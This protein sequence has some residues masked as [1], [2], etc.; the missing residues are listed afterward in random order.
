MFYATTDHAP[1]HSLSCLGL[2]G[3]VEASLKSLLGLLKNKMHVAWQY[4]ENIDAD[5]IFYNP[6]SPLAQAL[7]RREEKN[8][9]GHVFV[10][11]SDEDPGQNGL[12]LPLRAE[13]LLQCLESAAGKVRH[14]TAATEQASLCERLDLLLQNKT[15]I[16]VEITAGKTTGILNPTRKMIQWPHALDADAVAQMVVSDVGLRPLHI[17][18]LNTLRNIEHKLTEHLSWDAALWAIGIGTSR[19]Q[20]LPRLHAD[21]SYRLT[22]WPDFG[23]IGRRGSDIKCTA[24]LT[25]KSMTPRELAEATGF[26]E[27]R[28]YGFINACALCGLLEETAAVARIAPAAMKAQNDSLFSGGMFQKIRRALAL[29][30]NGA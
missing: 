10:P 27:A 8:A 11:C 20:L 16:A 30:A 2:D 29:G 15:V 17:T 26:S 4:V 18:D 24:L 22:R 7:L 19:A 28:V 5:V 9:S 21:K 14:L 3:R 13:R 6:A 25:H 12:G 1:V 23:L